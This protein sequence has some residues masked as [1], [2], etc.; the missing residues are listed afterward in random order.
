MLSMLISGPEGPG[1]AI[2]IYLQPLIE[3]LI[4]LWVN[5][6][7]TYDASTRKNFMLRAALLWIIHD[8]PA[9][10]N[11]SGHSTK[12]RLLFATKKLGHYGYQRV[13]SFATWAIV[14]SSQMIIYGENIKLLLMAP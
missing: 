14:D 8:F 1:D 7:D 11:L 3:E 12:G 6:V 5:G 9:Y 10:G 4:D 2:D 13:T